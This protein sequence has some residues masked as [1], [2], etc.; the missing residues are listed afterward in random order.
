M[1]F[2]DFIE[3]DK[4]NE[5]E[6]IDAVRCGFQAF[7]KKREEQK[8]QAE[9][10]VVLSKVLSAE[11][12]DLKSIVKWMI[13]HDLTIQ[14]GHVVKSGKVK[15]MSKEVLEALIYKKSATIV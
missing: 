12:E 13:D 6:I 8:K 5:V 9:K 7:K 4:L 3:Q 11:G 10:K 1:R 14:N 15:T 2:K